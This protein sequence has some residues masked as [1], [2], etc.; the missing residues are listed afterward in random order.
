MIRKNMLS[1]LYYYSKFVKKFLRGKSV[2]DSKIDKTAIV[3]AGCN[4]LGCTIGRYSYM[5]Y[6]CEVVNTEIGSFC[7][8]ASGI[9]IGEAIATHRDGET[10]SETLGD[11]ADSGID[12]HLQMVFGDT[13][14]RCSGENH[15][16]GAESVGSK[17]EACTAKREGQCL[18]GVVE[19]PTLQ[20]GEV[21]LVALHIER[22]AELSAGTVGKC[23]EGDRGDVGRRSSGIKE[24]YPHNT[25]KGME[26]EVIG[27][28][29]PRSSPFAA[30]PCHHR[31]D[32][33]GKS[34]ILLLTGTARLRLAEVNDRVRKVGIGAATTAHNNIF[35]IVGVHA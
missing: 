14:A 33:L 10:L 29:V 1:L 16:E 2:A 11:T 30:V 8:L 18:V 4:V 20:I 15:V 26:I 35:G 24:F 27:L 34:N 32:L 19:S 6:D 25:A 23:V 31:E 9:H 28:V 5:G 22:S 17:G 21:G 3:N 13:R 7:S 12:S